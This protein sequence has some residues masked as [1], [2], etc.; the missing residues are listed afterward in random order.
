MIENRFKTGKKG[1]RKD[2][3]VKKGKNYGKRK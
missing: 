3:S 2:L 1:Y